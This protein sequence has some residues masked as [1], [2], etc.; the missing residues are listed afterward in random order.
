MC[1]YVFVFLYMYMYLYNGIYGGSMVTT[2][3]AQAQLES[4]S[5]D[6]PEAFSDAWRVVREGSKRVSQA[7]K[8][9]EIVYHGIK[10]VDYMAYGI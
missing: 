9:T 3:P 8:T 6:S 1:M 2:A 10:Y 4:S 5:E 7:P